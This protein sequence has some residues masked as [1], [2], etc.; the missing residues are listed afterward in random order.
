MD[1]TNRCPDCNRIVGHGANC[2]YFRPILPRMDDCQD[3]KPI[4]PRFEE[5][6]NWMETESKF[7]HAC[8]DLDQEF[9]MTPTT[10]LPTDP[11]AR[12]AIPLCRGLL[13]YFP[14]ALAVVAEVSRV[15]S[16]QHHPDKPIHW[17]RSKSTDEAD[18]LMRHLI[19]R[20]K[21]DSDGQRHTA[22]VAW[23]ALALLQKEIE[24]EKG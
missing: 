9:P 7:A 13:D 21:I 18:A 23:R 2:K 10:S 24:A 20:G 16:Q 3:E 17:D 15:G 12:K 14:D 11:S 5:R 19:D 22:K 4:S 8:P 6:L 1:E